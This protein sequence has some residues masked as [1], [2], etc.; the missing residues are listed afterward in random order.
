MLK[1]ILQT[2]LTLIKNVSILV[3]SFLGFSFT[4]SDKKNIEKEVVEKDENDDPGDNGVNKTILFQEND[5]DFKERKAVFKNEEI[6]KNNLPLI[7][8]EIKYKHLGITIYNDEKLNIIISKVEKNGVADKFGLKEGDVL[9]KINDVKA[10]NEKTFLFVKKIER[11]E[12]EDMDVVY[13]RDGKEL[14]V[15]I[16]NIE[17]KIVQNVENVIYEKINNEIETKVEPIFLSH[18]LVE[19]VCVDNKKNIMNLSSENPLKEVVSTI[20]P[21]SQY[22]KETI[23][24]TAVISEIEKKK[25]N[26]QTKKENVKQKSLEKKQD[27]K[28]EE[29]K[30]QKKD[31]KKITTEEEA[32]LIFNILEEDKKEKEEKIKSNIL[33]EKKLLQLLKVDNRF[34]MQFLP[35]LIFRRKMVRNMY[36]AHLL[37]NSLISARRTLGED[38]DYKTI[39]HLALLSKRKTTSNFISLTYDN[40]YQI[41]MF[42]IQ[43]RQEYGNLLEVEPTLIEIMDR[44]NY[45]EQR[46]IARY[47]RLIEHKKELSKKNQKR[48]I[49][50]IQK[51]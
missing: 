50:V 21:T 1:K 14:K 51:K 13:I 16:S 28:K 49:L 46:T 17:K 9:I 39:D 44:I 42:K 19:D 11:Y 10:L 26:I 45:L 6:K 8:N 23:M 31:D 25:E 7:Q 12:Q 40:L 20:K 35:F 3:I 33:K 24:A 34:K 32:L 5:E 37:S 22:L 36:K 4:K 47:Q 27:E 30:N 18:D 43:L 15:T 41:D 2:F 38:I 29:K 48:K